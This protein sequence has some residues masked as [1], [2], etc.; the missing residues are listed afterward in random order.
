MGDVTP[1]HGDHSYRNAP[2]QPTRTP[3]KVMSIEQQGLTRSVQNLW[4]L[5]VTKSSKS[6]SSRVWRWVEQLGQGDW[7]EELGKMG[8]APLWRK[9]NRSSLISI[10]Y[11][12]RHNVIHFFPVT[13][14]EWESTSW[15]WNTASRNAA[16][17]KYRSLWSLACFSIWFTKPWGI[18]MA[19]SFP[20]NFD[21]WRC[22]TWDY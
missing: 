10:L 14:M 2:A 12:Q 20:T 22:K 21:V 9:S 1:S 7:T 15:C 19:R 8:L 16:F 6:G 4:P 3:I 18:W 17:K 11:S 13:T 5:W